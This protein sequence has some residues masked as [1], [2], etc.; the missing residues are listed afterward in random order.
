MTKSALMFGIKRI[1]QRP[2]PRR[3]SGASNPPPL[4]GQDG[5]LIRRGSSRHSRPEGWSYRTRLKRASEPGL[6]VTRVLERLRS[7]VGLPQSIVAG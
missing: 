1:A 4:P 5:L 7:T 3:W 2:P 6:H